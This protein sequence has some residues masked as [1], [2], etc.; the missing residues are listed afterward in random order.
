MAAAGSWEEELR[1]DSRAVGHPVNPREPYVYLNS[2]LVPASAAH[3][4]VFDR[5]FAYGDALFE[6]LKLVRGRPVFFDD[7][8]RRL[9]QAMRDSGFMSTLEPGGLRNQAEA[10]A[11]ANGISEGRL[12]IM[13]SRGTPA[14]AGG[15]DPGTDL[16]P[17]LLLTAEQFAGH[18]RKIYTSGVKCVTVPANRGRY[19][20]VKSTSLFATVMARRLAHE[21]GAYE[22]IFTTGHGRMLEGSISNIFFHDGEKLITAPE[23]LPILA[24]VTR[25]KVLD[26]AGE[27]GIAAFSE[28]ARLEDLDPDNTSAFLTGSVLGICPVSTIDDLVLKLD[29][30]LTGSLS[31]RLRALELDSIG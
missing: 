17:M 30:G 2:R 14:A 7:H 22:A 4:S 21:A 9:R 11:E 19:A 31:E 10:L 24:G 29:T 18:P 15:V 26:A 13:L 25:Q 8:F 6:T 27:A 5:A 28:A 20:S 3:V 23:E 1:D 12:R 16:T